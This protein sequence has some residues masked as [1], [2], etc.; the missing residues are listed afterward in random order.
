[1]NPDGSLAGAVLFNSGA[2]L[3]TLFRFSILL[4]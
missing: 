1:M 2:N 4:F 3:P